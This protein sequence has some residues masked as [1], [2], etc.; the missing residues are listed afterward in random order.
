MWVSDHQVNNMLLRMEVVKRDWRREKVSFDKIIRR[1]E[2]ICEQLNLHRVDPI[3]IAKET[4][5]NLYDGVKTEELDFFA[6]NKCA[7]KIVDDPEY[8]KL[9]AGLCI[10]NLHKNTDSDFMV[11][12]DKLYNNKDKFGKPTPLITAEYY[13]FVKNN[14][15][16]SK[17]PLITVEILCLI[18]LVLRHWKEHIC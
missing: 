13:N 11:V 4:I 1:I 14:I 16:R 18:S 5:Q 2:G 7:E 12:T 6:A 15:G 8:N 3:E 9:A 10:S 17:R